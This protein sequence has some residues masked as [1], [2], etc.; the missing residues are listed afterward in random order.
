MSRL[1]IRAPNWVGDLAMATPVLAAAAEDPRWD[2]VHV[3]LRA[4][5]APLL[6][7]LP[8]PVEVHPIESHDNEAETLAGLGA[9]AALLLTSSLRS[10]WLARRGGIP[11]RAG[12]GTGLCRLLLTH[13][14]RPTTIGGRRAPAPTAHLYRDVAGLLGLAVAD[15]H[16]RLAAPA[17]ARRSVRGRLGFEGPYVLASP[18]A[19]FGAAKLWPPERFAAALDEVAGSRGWEAVVV[20]GPGEEALTEAV[21]AAANLPVHR[22]QADLAELRSLVAEAELLL[23]GDSGPRWIAAA[24]DVP[25]VSVLGP[26]S[27]E[28]TAT[29]LEHARIVRLEGL[30]CAPCLE[31]RCPLGHHRC[32]KELAVEP[33]VAAASELLG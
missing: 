14:V 12:S 33:V 23:V 16:P 19:A 11:I 24:F 8:F 21:I 20:G 31:R 13:A 25:C 5:L 15:L 9:D 30:E 27:P 17:A 1:V 4:H 7:E 18:G 28:Q 3:V 10:A 32:M 26:T 29:S 2:E 22:L 6:T